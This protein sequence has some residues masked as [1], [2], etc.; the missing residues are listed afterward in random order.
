MTKTVLV[1]DDSANIRRTLA[2]KQI[3]ILKSH[4]AKGKDNR[5]HIYI[6]PAR[7]QRSE[8]GRSFKPETVEVLYH[9]NGRVEQ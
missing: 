2:G 7:S 1:V 8:N 5:M 6:L 9:F 3:Q 4:S